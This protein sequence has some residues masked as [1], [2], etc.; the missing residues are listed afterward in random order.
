M[1]Q[2]EGSDEEGDLMENQLPDPSCR[3]MLVSLGGSPEPVLYTLGQQEP[4]YVLFFVS[5]ESAGQIQEIIREL[6][7]PCRDFDRILSPSAEILGDCYR[8]LRDHLP[9]KLAQWGLSPQEL[10]VDYT[11]GTKS[12]SAALVLATIEQAHRYSYVG[13]VERDKGGVGVVLGGREQMHYIQNPWKEVAR[14]ERKRISLLFATARY[15]TA[16][17]EIQGILTH[18]EDGEREFWQAMAALVEGY[19]DWDNFSPR[20]AKNKLGRAFS[21]LKPYAGGARGQQP[22]LAQF[23]LDVEANLEFL[24]RLT[25]PDGRDE[26]YILDLIANADRRARV[27]GKYE[28][29]VARLYSCLERGAKFRLQREYGVST[30]DVKVDQLPEALRSEFEQKYRDARESKIRLPLFASY[31]LLDILG[32]VLG[33]RFVARQEEILKLLNLRNLSPLG[34]GENPVGQEGYGRFRVLLVELL[35]IDEDALPK[36]ATLPL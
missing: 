31:R 34:H 25:S 21:F 26:A 3:A 12:M 16:R 14:E 36:F 35:G 18:V 8:A 10:L 6:P 32:D 24:N 1:E 11:G 7:Y 13:G 20:S 15:E 5:A 30:E 27:E 2:E 17:Q 23:V 33:Q 28:D 4:E 9:S 29:G 22:R 19:C